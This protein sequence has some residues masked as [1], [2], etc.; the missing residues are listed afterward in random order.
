[1]G[2]LEIES[3]LTDIANAITSTDVAQARIAEINAAG[4]VIT[5]DLEQNYPNYLEILRKYQSIGLS[6]NSEGYLCIEVTT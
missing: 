4:K 3:R 5:D 6:V 1:M 2:R